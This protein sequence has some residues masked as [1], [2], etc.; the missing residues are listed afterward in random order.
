[1]VTIVGVDPAAS[2][3]ATSKEVSALWRRFLPEHSTTGPTIS[4]DDSQIV[5]AVNSLPGLALP[6]TGGL[7]VLLGGYI[8]LIGPLNYLVLR[9]LDRREWAWITMPVLI[10]VFA[11]AAYGYGALLR[12]VEVIVNE[13]S[14]VR[15]APDAAEGSALVYLGVFSPTRGTYQ[16][17]VAG[18]ALLSSPI[19]GDIFG[20]GDGLTMDVLQGN[21]SRVRDLAVGVNTLRVIRAESATVVPRISATLRLVDGVLTGSVTNNSD[22]SL[23]KVA[24]VLGSSV[25]VLGDLPA[26]AKKDVSLRLTTNANQMSLSDRILGQVF[27]GDTGGGFSEES[28]RQLVRASVLNQLTYDPFVGYSGRLDAETPVLLAWGTQDVL[29]VRIEGQQPRRVANTLFYVPISMTVSGKTTFAGDLI[30]SSV[31]ASDAMFFSKDPTWLNL[32]AGS[33]TIAYRPISFEGTLEPSELA[34]SMT[35]GEPMRDG[36]GKPIGPLPVVPVR[37][38]DE[39]NTEPAGCEPRVQDLPEVELFDRT[40]EGAWVRL[41][42]LTPGGRYVVD[43]PA[44]YVDP[45]SGGVLVRFVNDQPDMQ[46]GFQFGVAI[47]GHVE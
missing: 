31:V 32:G 43:D 40:G 26:G 24:V 36:E 39:A 46:F 41:P 16:V 15:G 4:N 23:E 21:P 18:G 1:M 20:T 7:L 42:H 44:R 9:R 10:A 29:D 25:A 3:L 33:A 34:I 22:T 13:I 14:I 12:G 5:S 17:A 11:V 38:T 2:W 28:Q 37:C 6:P 47:T 35:M 30:R 45:A 27:F 19:A 8:L